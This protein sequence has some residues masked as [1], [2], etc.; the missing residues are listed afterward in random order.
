MGRPRQVTG[1]IQSQQ[2]SAF[3]QEHVCA[4]S[5]DVLDSSHQQM[6]YVKEEVSRKAASGGSC[7]M[8]RMFTVLVVDAVMVCSNTDRNEEGPVVHQSISLFPATCIFINLQ[9]RTAACRDVIVVQVSQ[10]LSNWHARAGE[11]LTNRSIVETVRL[12]SL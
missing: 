2:S 8:A 11:G 5:D 1:P 10:S 3:V 12:A 4:P 6:P 7:R 9:L